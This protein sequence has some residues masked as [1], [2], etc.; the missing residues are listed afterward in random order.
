MNEYLLD[1]NHASALW[2]NNPTLVTRVGN[3]ADAELSLCLPSIGELCFMVY[4]SV[5]VAENERSLRYSLSRFSHHDFDEDAADHFGRI[6]AQLKTIGR[7]IPDVDSQI[8][9]IAVSRELTLL[10][11]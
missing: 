5:R 8:A 11:A 3:L 4:K 10:T 1:T 7:P 6:K 9:A 2:Q